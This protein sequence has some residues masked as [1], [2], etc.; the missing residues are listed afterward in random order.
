MTGVGN[1]NMSGEALHFMTPGEPSS[2]PG[3]YT[4]GAVTEPSAPEMRTKGKA[5]GRLPNLSDGPINHTYLQ[6]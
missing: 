6:G 3:V 1:C 2:L 5:L 4:V